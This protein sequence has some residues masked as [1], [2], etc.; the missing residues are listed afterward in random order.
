MTDRNQT[1]GTRISAS[2]QSATVDAI[3]RHHSDLACASPATALTAR[4]E[5]TVRRAGI[6]HQARHHAPDVRPL[7]AVVFRNYGVADR[8]RRRGSPAWLSSLPASSA[9]RSAFR[10]FWLPSAPSWL[11]SWRLH[12]DR[13]RHGQEGLPESRRRAAWRFALFSTLPWQRTAHRSGPVYSAPSPVSS[14][15]TLP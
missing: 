2:P 1:R 8:P 13:L 14:R 15:R 6:C 4:V 12:P 11:S 5:A 10:L 9:S 7:C 3:G